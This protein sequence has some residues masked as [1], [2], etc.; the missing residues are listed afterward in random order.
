MKLYFALVM[1]LVEMTVLETE[2]CGGF[3]KYWE[4]DKKNGGV[5]FFMGFVDNRSIE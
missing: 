1:P 4:M 5:L 2:G 3:R